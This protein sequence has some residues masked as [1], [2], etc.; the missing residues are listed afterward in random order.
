MFTK[1]KITLY[2]NFI[3]FHRTVSRTILEILYFL[4]S[5]S[6]GIDFN[7]LSIFSTFSL[8]VR[9]S[10]GN[11]RAHNALENSRDHCRVLELRRN[12]YFLH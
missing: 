8:A 6:H 2:L 7:F 11:A 5:D 4:E 12:R 10:Y 3:I 1:I 9:N